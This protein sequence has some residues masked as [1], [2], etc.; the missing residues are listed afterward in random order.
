MENKESWP[1]AKRRA[2]FKALEQDLY[3]YHAMK[4]QLQEIEEDIES[5]AYPQAAG[6][7]VGY[8]V[9]GEKTNKKGEKEELRVYDFV[10]GHSEGQTSDPT[11][12]K[13]Q[14]LWDYHKFHMSSLAYREMLRRID[15]IDYL[16][17]IFRQRAERGELE[18]KLK[19][20]LIEEKYFN[21][22]L[23]DCGIW[24]SLNISKRTFYYW[25]RGIIRILAEQL[26]L[27]I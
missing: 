18:A 14:K 15:A 26:G 25:Q 12:M 6:G 16:L 20:R 8:R 11:A 3:T 7:E 24:E 1:S 4:K 10:V 2:N 22:R 27:I 23:T 17:S 5:I 19:L 13:A 21:R 9:I